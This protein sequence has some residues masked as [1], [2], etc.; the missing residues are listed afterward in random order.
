MTIAVGRFAKSLV[1]NLGIDQVNMTINLRDMQ[2][3]Y[4]R[5]PA[6]A[7][8]NSRGAPGNRTAAIASKVA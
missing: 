2:R 1:S 8:S 7:A 5:K 4:L 6:E 3:L